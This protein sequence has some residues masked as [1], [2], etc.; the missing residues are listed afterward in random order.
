LGQFLPKFD[1]QK[2]SLLQKIMFRDCV[3]MTPIIFT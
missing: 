3:S 1:L 2:S